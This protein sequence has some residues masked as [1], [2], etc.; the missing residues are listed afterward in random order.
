MSRRSARGRRPGSRGDPYKAYARSLNRLLAGIR[1]DAPC[2]QSA[3]PLQHEWY[4]LT[5]YVGDVSLGV[6]C[7]RCGC[8]GVVPGPA[9]KEW[10]AAYDAPANPYRFGR[11]E[12]VRFI[13]SRLDHWRAEADW[14]ARGGPS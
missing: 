7:I 13:N 12:A 10:D 3:D 2:R 5:T 14:F 4:V 8:D 6:F 1:P 11:P 9:K